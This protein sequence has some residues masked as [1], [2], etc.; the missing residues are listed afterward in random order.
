MC[1]KIWSKTF[2]V[3]LNKKLKK[4]RHQWHCCFGETWG[5]KHRVKVEV[6]TFGGR[7]SFWYE[8]P[9]YL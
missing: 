6:L 1:N 9:R 8:G 5:I 2:V 7:V 4:Q 3:L